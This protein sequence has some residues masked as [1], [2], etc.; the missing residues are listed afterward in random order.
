MFKQAGNP[1]VEITSAMIAQSPYDKTGNDFAVALGVRDANDHD[2]HDYWYGVLNDEVGNKPDPEKTRWELTIMDLEK[3]GWKF[4]GDLTS[5][6]L[7]TLIGVK[8]VAWV[9]HRQ[10]EYNGE[11]RDSYDVKTLGGNSY[12]PKAVNEADAL[13]KLRALM[14]T[15]APAPAA[16]ASQPAATSPATQP[17]AAVEIDPFG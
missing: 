1:E 15:K 7:Q 10:Y 8:T 3:L 5:A 9:K 2:Q 6:N 16:K 17:A 14:G 12:G 4:G 11:T 13:A